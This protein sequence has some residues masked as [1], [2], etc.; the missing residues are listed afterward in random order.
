M[1]ELS[2]K[3]ALVTG[4][5]S[6]I[7]MDLARLLAAEGCNLVLVARRRERLEALATELR[8]ASPGRVEVVAADLAQ[9]G[10]AALVVGHLDSTGLEVDLLV[11]NAGFGLSG[12]FL[13]TD[14]DVERE[15]VQ[16]NVVALLELTKLVGRRM[17]ARGGGRILNV[18]STAAFQPGPLM[19]VYYA[20]K[21]FVLSFSE[22][23]SEELRGTGVSVTTLCPGPTRTQFQDRADLGGT[24]LVNTLAGMASSLSVARTGL[25]GA[26]RRKR[27]V[28]PGLLNTL[29]VLSVRL[30]PRRWVLATVRRLQSKQ[31]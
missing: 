30:T 23:L 12:P 2:G 13:A 4:A 26:L 10:A 22:A 17:A 9:P 6:G 19:S 1:G 24:R 7:G 21:A 5:S 15:M 27:L 3:T 11:N 25:R 14:M 16:L 28:V 29:G 8:G 31:A 18:A 20:S